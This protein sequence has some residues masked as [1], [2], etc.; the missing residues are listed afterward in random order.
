VRLVLAACFALILFDAT[1]ASSKQSLE[2]QSLNFEGRKRTSYLFIPD[3]APAETALPLIVLLHGSGEDGP[4]LANPWRSIASKAG[5]ILVAPDAA[6]RMR[7]D[8]RDDHPD[9]IRELVEDAEGKHMV[10]TRRVYLFGHS[11]GGVYALTLALLES[12][13]FAAV[14]VHAGALCSPNGI[15]AQCSSEEV[16][17]AMER[18][19]RKIPFGLW[20]GTFDSQVPLD[21]VERSQRALEM[22]GFPAELHTMSGATH[23]Y[24]VHAD[25]VN[26]AAWNFLRQHQLDGPSQFQLYKH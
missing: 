14:A 1:S 8:A 19:K 7:W 10:D 4:S 15:Y 12:Q 22:H 26:E 24:Y 17:Q 6:D 5:I 25:E 13:Y 11:N 23:N 18:A 21:R 20:S 16:E 9:F 3:S 2:K